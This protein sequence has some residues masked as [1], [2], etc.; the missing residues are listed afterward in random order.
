MICAKKGSRPWFAQTLDKTKGCQW[1]ISKIA[2]YNSVVWIICETIGDDRPGQWTTWNLNCLPVYHTY[3][4]N[5]QQ[6]KQHSLL[7]A[8]SVSEKFCCLY[9][10]LWEL[11]SQYTYYVTFPQISG[12]ASSHFRTATFSSKM[13]FLTASIATMRCGVPRAPVA[14]NPS[15]DAASPPCSESFTP[16]ISSAHSVSSNSTKAP[17]KSKTTSPTVTVASTDYSGETHDQPDLSYVQ[18]IF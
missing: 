6:I 16:S 1:G 10:K 9:L 5:T 7:F 11:L 8:L 3:I 18:A 17:S 12:N 14:G 15:P 2:N 4:S 13:A